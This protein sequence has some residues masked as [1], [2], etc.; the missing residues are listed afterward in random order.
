MGIEGV[1]VRGE[2]MDLTG[3]V[4][5]QKDYFSE[6]EMVSIGFRKNSLEKLLEALDDF[7]SAI[8]EVEKADLNKSEAEVRLTELD[9]IRQSIH[10]ALKHIDGWARMKRVPSSWKIMPARS[11]IIKEGYGSVLIMASWNCPLYLSLIPLIGAIA[12]GNCAVIR[13]SGRAPATGRVLKDMINGIFDKKY[14]YVIEENLPYSEVLEQDYDFIFFSGGERVGKSVMKTAAERLIPVS[15]QL[16]GKNPCIIDS[17]VDIEMAARKIAWGKILNA[18]QTALAPDYILIPPEIK[19]EFIDAL[20]AS[21]RKLLGDSYGNN[22]YS[23]IIN[24]HHYMQLRTLIEKCDDCIGG[25][26]NDSILRIEPAIFPNCTWND[27]IMREEIYGPI[28]PVIEYTDAAEMLRE[29]KRRPKPVACYIFSEEED[30]VR[31]MLRE[32]SFGSGCINDV[33]IQKA[34]VNLPLGG[35]GRSGMGNYNGKAGFDLFTHEKSVVGRR[36]S[37]DHRSRYKP[38]M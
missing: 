30:F 28:L 23:K 16:G 18:G 17:H 34:A 2:G 33:I 24:L 6:R 15:L 8:F 31:T 7:E 22:N 29:L 38:F 19:K 32:V 1:I 20:V 27:S 11:Y 5:L 14:V 35:V 9:L 13:T 3:I 10:Y 25:I 37:F 12:A 4:S 36:N 26:Y 21:F